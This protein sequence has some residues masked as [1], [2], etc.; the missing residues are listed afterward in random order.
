MLCGIGHQRARSL[1]V[2]APSG[3]SSVLLSNLIWGIVTAGG[4]AMATTATNS[5]RARREHMGWRERCI[6]RTDPYVEFREG[7]RLEAFSMPDPMH[8]SG[9][10][11]AVFLHKLLKL[12]SK[13]LV[14]IRAHRTCI[15]CGVNLFIVN[16]C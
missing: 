10:A 1:E 8:F 5:I 11:L 13:R 9:A 4:I 6:D 3:F 12:V 2:Q 14:Q 7:N 15:D 16:G